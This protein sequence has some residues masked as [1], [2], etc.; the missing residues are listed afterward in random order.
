LASQRG[1][2]AYAALFNLDL[3]GPPGA[4]LFL[5]LTS[6]SEALKRDFH[7][8]IV[9]LRRIRPVYAILAVV[10]PLAVISLS[11][12]L[13]QSAD[14]FRLAAGPNLSVMIILALAIA[15]IMEETGWHGY[16]VDSLRAKTGMLKATL[17][18]AALWSAWH[19][20]LVL[21]GGTYQNKLAR[22][23]NPLYLANFFVSVIPA[24][25]IANWF[26]YKNS[27]SIVSAFLVQAMLNAPSVLL[28]AGQIAKCI[29]TLLYAA[30]TVVLV[31]SDRALFTA[32]P[33]I[34]LVARAQPTLNRRVLSR[35]GRACP[36][37]PRI[38][39]SLHARWLGLRSHEQTK[40]DCPHRRNTCDIARRAW[41]H[42]EGAAGLH[43]AI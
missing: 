30:T 37:H 21:I 33:A 1:L 40:W 19:A 31:A 23:D 9:N 16:G 10:L 13:G 7:D 41:E 29:A 22:M 42:R 43:T 35:H 20:P 25:I 12:W 27:R 32:C 17:L 6:R 4:T 2:E 39:H 3:L 24:A 15:P 5:I 11:L 18:F 34:S 26:Y 38:A 14:Q 8:R 28:N 36:G